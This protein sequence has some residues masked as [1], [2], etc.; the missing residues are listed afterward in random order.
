MNNY[1]YIMCKSNRDSAFDL[2]K[3]KYSRHEKILIQ[4]YKSIKDKEE[5][6]NQLNEE[7]HLVNQEL[8]DKNEIINTQNNELKATLKHLKDTQHQLL[9]TEKMASLGILT[10]GVAHEINN[11]L[12]YILGGYVGLENYFNE[13][14]LQQDETIKTLLDGIKTGVNRAADIVLGLNQFSRDSKNNNEIC[15]IHSIIDNCLLMLNY[16]LDHRINLKK[17]YAKDIPFISGNVGK[18]HQVFTNILSNAIQSIESKGKISITT[19]K[20]EE[21]L[22]IKITD[23]GS[24]ISDEDL[25]KITDPFFT[26]K[27]PGKGTGLG[28][29]ITYK[30]IQ[31]HKGKIEFHST[32][33]KGTRVHIS[34]PIKN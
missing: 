30:I 28:L 21:N 33:N 4:A 29:S 15:D 25:P 12:N 27:D 13:I 34:L 11:P 7:L 17:E 2:L 20:K 26:T 1:F 9:Q 14:G 8:N 22:L 24:G 5:E 32:I 3:E 6:L 10:A 31:E 19:Q 23:T 18:L 16:Q